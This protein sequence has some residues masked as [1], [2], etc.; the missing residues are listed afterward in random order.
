MK[1]KNN[2]Y[3]ICFSVRPSSN[4][5]FF[6]YIYLIDNYGMHMNMIQTIAH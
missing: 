3:L 6:L 4:F 1:S 5:N 2:L